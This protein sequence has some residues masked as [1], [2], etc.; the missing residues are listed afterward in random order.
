MGNCFNPGPIGSPTAQKPTVEDSNDTQTE[1]QDVSPDHIE[2]RALPG[3]PDREITADDRIVR[4]M[5]DFAGVGDE[6]VTFAKGDLLRVN[7]KTEADGWWLATH[8]K[9]GQHGYIPSNYVCKNDNSLEAQDW[10]LDVEAKEARGESEILLMLPGNCAGTF[11]VRRCNDERI[12]AVLSVRYDK[13]TG[14]PAVAHYRMRRMDDG[15]VYFNT[16][17]TFHNIFDLIAHYSRHADGLATR[18]SV[19][20]PRIQPVP[21]DMQMLEIDREAI[22]K[23]TQLGEGHFGEVWK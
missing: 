1:N 6:D 23:T 5:F 4:A 18:L 16:K 19:P 9:T 20:C 7:Q 13:E 21:W 15:G 12:P 2:L 14:E 3:L 8:L 10:F 11:L 22:T 17:R